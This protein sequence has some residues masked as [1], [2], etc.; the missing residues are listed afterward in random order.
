MLK[1]NENIPPATHLPTQVKATRNSVNDY[2]RIVNFSIKVAS[3]YKRGLID[4]I[5]DHYIFNCIKWRKHFPL[6]TL[7]DTINI[8]DLHI[9][10]H[11]RK[12]YALSSDTANNSI[13]FIGTNVISFLYK[14]DVLLL[15][16]HKIDSKL[17]SYGCHSSNSC[18]RLLFDRQVA[19][20]VTI[21]TSVTT[22]TSP[23][24]HH[25][26]EPK[27]HN[28]PVHFKRSVFHLP[29]NRPN[30]LFHDLECHFNESLPRDYE[31]LMPGKFGRKNGERFLGL[32]RRENGERKKRE[33][34]EYG[35]QLHTCQMRRIH[36][37]SH[38][39]LNVWKLIELEGKSYLPI[40][41]LGRGISNHCMLHV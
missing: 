3:V 18:T 22:T 39:F 33:W 32:L 2:E 41:S 17:D 34:K 7:P 30:G 29:L 16:T 20:P 28:H 40:P 27:A 24:H 14:D 37:L 25:R 31:K 36:T 8:R 13:L 5:K 15:S 38:N 6:I 10:H 26:S 1:F 23:V 19:Y 12:I 9:L 11:P 4:L 35:E 21:G